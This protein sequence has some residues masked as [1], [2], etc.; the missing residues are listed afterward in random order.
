MKFAR[1]LTVAGGEV[2]IVSGMFLLEADTA[3][4]AAIMVQSQAPLSGIA[5][6]AIGWD[7]DLETW[8]TGFIESSL[9]VDAKQQRLVIRETSA[10]LG[11]ACPISAR[12]ILPATILAN[13]A[14]ATGATF[15]A[16]AIPDTRLSHAVNLGTARAAIFRMAAELQIQDF[17]CQALPDGRIYCGPRGGLQSATLYVPANMFSNLTSLGGSL[18]AVPRIRPGVRLAVGNSEPVTITRVELASSTM[19]LAWSHT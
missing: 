14:D 8:F 11:A 10:V 3:G 2:R 4:R 16:N 17:A 5:T 15:V 18:Q 7:G 19:R 9:Q 12:N 13:I 1:K 6:L